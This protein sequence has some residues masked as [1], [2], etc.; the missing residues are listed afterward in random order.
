MIL[1]SLKIESSSP[2]ASKYP[3]LPEPFKLTAE[4]LEKLQTVDLKGKFETSKR[5][6]LESAGKAFCAEGGRLAKL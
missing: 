4:R 6:N 3:A 1:N 2:F 5:N